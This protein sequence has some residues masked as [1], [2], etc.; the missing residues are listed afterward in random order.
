[1]LNKIRIG[2]ALGGSGLFYY[3]HQNYVNYL[4]SDFQIPQRPSINDF[5]PDFEIPIDP[6]F[7]KKFDAEIKDYQEIA[8]TQH[9]KYIDEGITFTGETLKSTHGET[10]PNGIGT[11][12]EKP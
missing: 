8:A 9:R 4:I 1:M 3:D 12:E 11:L 6:E 2:L 7:E 5:K 10:I